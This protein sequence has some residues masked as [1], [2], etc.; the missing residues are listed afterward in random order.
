[1]SYI[2]NEDLRNLCIQNGWFEGGTEEQYEKLFE[3][4]TSGASDEKLS[5]MIYLC[6]D[7]SQEEILKILRNYKIMQTVKY[8]NTVYLTSEKIAENAINEIGEDNIKKYLF[9][10][11]E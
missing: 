3:A 5:I 4:N 6:S 9:G 7:T 10:I 8:P 2:S 11:E 1:M